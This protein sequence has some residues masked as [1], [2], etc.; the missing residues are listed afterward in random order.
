VVVV[1][2]GREVSG[3]GK[4]RG[5]VVVWKGREVSGVGKGRGVRKGRGRIGHAERG[6]GGIEEKKE[7]EVN[8]AENCTGMRNEGE[9]KW[10][11]VDAR[12]VL[13]VRGVE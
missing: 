3:V 5:V 12:G 2:K 6:R 11:G 1:W 9:G 4:G 13:E 7:T 8:K 10:N